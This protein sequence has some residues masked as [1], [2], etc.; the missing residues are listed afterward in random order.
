MARQVPFASMTRLDAPRLPRSSSVSPAFPV[1]GLGTRMCW[2]KETSTQRRA[3]GQ[4]LPGTKT[5]CRRA[6]YESAVGDPGEMHDRGVGDV[7]VA[8]DER[9]GQM[10]VENHARSRLGRSPR[11]EFLYLASGPKQHGRD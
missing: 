2:E 10:E 9:R 1:V 11:H 5:I 3:D 4:H 8:Y 7:M 6:W